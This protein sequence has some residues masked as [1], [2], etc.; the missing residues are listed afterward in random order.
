M[1]YLL[2]LALLVSGCAATKTSLTVS[3]PE[4]KPLQV[5]VDFGT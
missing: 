3:K 5:R 2:L 1:R 4:G